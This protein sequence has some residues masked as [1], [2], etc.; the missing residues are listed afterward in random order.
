MRKS[1]KLAILFNGAALLLVGASAAA[2]VRSLFVTEETPPCATRYAEG[3]QLA[4]ERYDGEKFT[5]AD[6]QA[7]FGG[8]DWGL[9]DNTSIVDVKDGPAKHAIQI[10]FAKSEPTSPQAG[11]RNGMGF[12]WRP[13]D[14]GGASAACLSYSARVQEDFDFGKGGRLPGLL[15]AAGQGTAKEQISASPGWRAD[16]NLDALMSGLTEARPLSSKRTS[17]LPRGRWMAIEQEMIL[18][19]PGMR[20]GVLRLW[21]DGAL[22]FEATD[23]AFRDKPEVKISGVLAEAVSASPSVSAGKTRSLLVSPLEL[24]W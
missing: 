21:L 24:R 2:I 9:L 11:D 18:N 7:R 5:P 20:D 17:E 15:A 19:T 14:A 8:N 1:T 10:R 12:T 3:T 4:L 23:L 6:L 16:G 13:H 22:K